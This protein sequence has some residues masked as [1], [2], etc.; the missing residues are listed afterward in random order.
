MP[1]LP[2]QPVSRPRQPKGLPN[3]DQYRLRRH[4]ETGLSGYELSASVYL[5][6]EAYNF[7]INLARMLMDVDPQK[8][9]E[10]GSKAIEAGSDV[11]DKLP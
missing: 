6:R 1:P 3:A 7:G 11:I 10:A 8:A 5:Q 9:I 4:A 2:L